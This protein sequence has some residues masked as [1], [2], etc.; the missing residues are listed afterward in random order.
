MNQTISRFLKNIYWSFIE[1]GKAEQEW[2]RMLETLSDRK[3]PVFYVISRSD[4]VGLFSYVEIVMRQIDY[5]LRNGY[6][7]IVDMRG[8]KNPYL[9]DGKEQTE[10]WWELY[11]EQPAGYSVEEA[12][13]SGKIERASEEK[14]SRIPYGGA[15]FKLKKSR[16]TWSAYYRTF[17]KPNETVRNYFAQEYETL[18]HSDGSRVLGVLVRGTD[19]QTAAGHPVM[20]G[21][22]EVISA[23]KKCMKRY[24]RIYLAT[25]EHVNVERF[26]A[27]FPGRVLVN[28]R[29]Y[30]DEKNFEERSINEIRFDRENDKYLCGLEYLSSILLL[31]KCGGLVGGLCGGTVAAVYLNDYQYRDLIYFDKGRQNGG[32]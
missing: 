5:A 3:N 15:S 31:S 27:E 16:W 32:A 6:I 20:P 11:F 2:M 10:N 4:Y 30:Y 9:E 21:V 7:P 28:R 19:Y 18:M 12:Y 23:V 22:D 17:F 1:A 24:D 25:E 8:S 26:E 14:R 13:Q 29:M